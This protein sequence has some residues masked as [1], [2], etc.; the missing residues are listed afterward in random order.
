MDGIGVRAR[1]SI[2]DGRNL[3]IALSGR[4]RTDLYGEIRGT[5]VRRGA[6]GLREHSHGFDAEL[7]AGPDDPEGD[8][9]AIGDQQAPDLARHCSRDGGSRHS[10]HDGG[11]LARNAPMPSW[12]SFDTR[13]SAI[14]SIEYSTA[15]SRGRWLMAPISAFAAA[16]AS[17]PEVTRSLTYFATTR[18]RSAASATACTSPISFAR[19]AEKRAPVR[20]SSRAAERP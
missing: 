13:R 12:P 4:C 11:R 1:R 6:V 17:G 3:Q 5:H 7:A 8:L 19:S 16:S 9:A 20:N 2:D 15:L 10:I 14:A 18:S